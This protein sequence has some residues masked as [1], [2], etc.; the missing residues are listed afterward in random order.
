MYSG[1]VIVTSMWHE[2][3]RVHV[4]AATRERA[5]PVLANA[6]I[7]LVDDRAER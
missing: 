4:E 6:G 2:G 1:G 7:A 3:D 5:M